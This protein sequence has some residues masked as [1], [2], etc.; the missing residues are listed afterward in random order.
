MSSNH[1]TKFNQNGYLVAMNKWHAAYTTNSPTI[2]A[3]AL[4]GIRSR[5]TAPVDVP[6]FSL[7]HTFN[8][9]NFQWFRCGRIQSLPV[10]F[11]VLLQG[12]FITHFSIWPSLSCEDYPFGNKSNDVEPCNWHGSQIWCSAAKRS[13]LGAKTAK[14]FSVQAATNNKETGFIRKCRKVWI[15]KIAVA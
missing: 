8:K 7:K 2:V 4:P 14:L 13:K 3:K 12:A 5:R 1:P 11:A 10:H 9:T 15:W 6:I